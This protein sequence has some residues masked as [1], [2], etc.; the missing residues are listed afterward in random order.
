MRKISETKTVYYVIVEKMEVPID[1]TDEE[2]DNILMSKA[3]LSDVSTEG[4]DYMWS[5]NDDL[6]YD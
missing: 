3:I 2:I 4:K 1:T 6:L 5:Y